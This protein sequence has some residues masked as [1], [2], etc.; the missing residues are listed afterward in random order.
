MAQLRGKNVSWICRL[1]PCI[2]RDMHLSL[3]EML[4]LYETKHLP[5]SCLL[6]ELVM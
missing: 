5:A 4:E 1:P 3:G 6:C 2:S